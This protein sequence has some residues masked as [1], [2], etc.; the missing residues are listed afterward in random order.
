MF[1]GSKK[2]ISCITKNEE[3]KTDNKMVKKNEEIKILQKK[4]NIKKKTK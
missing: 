1:R 3:T 2:S 4:R